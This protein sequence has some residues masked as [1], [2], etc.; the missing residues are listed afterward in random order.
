[1]R[2][3]VQHEKRLKHHEKLILEVARHY[4][5]QEPRF[6]AEEREE[7][8]W[9]LAEFIFDE[10]HEW[11]ADDDTLSFMDRLAA[12]NERVINDDRTHS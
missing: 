7:R 2:R 1:M 5:D 6:K 4:V 8:A 10:I 12:M 9:Q 11:I 3:W